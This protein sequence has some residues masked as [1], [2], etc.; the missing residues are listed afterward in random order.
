MNLSKRVTARAAL[1]VQAT[2][3]LALAAPDAA[4]AATVTGA[5]TSVTFSGTGGDYITQDQAL[6]LQPVQLRYHGHGLG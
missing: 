4:H 2:G 3:T 5:G 1:G 6:V